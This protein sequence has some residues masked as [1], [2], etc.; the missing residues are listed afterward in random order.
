MGFWFPAF[1]LHYVTFFDSGVLSFCSN[2]DGIKTEVS[3]SYL[4]EVPQLFLAVRA[5]DYCRPLSCCLMKNLYGAS[6]VLRRAW[7]AWA[8]YPCHL[9]L[10]ARI[11]EA[12]NPRITSA[13]P[14]HSINTE[15]LVLCDNISEGITLAELPRGNL[16]IVKQCSSVKGGGDVSAGSN[17]M[18]NSPGLSS[19]AS[20]RSQKTQ[21]CLDRRDYGYSEIMR[22]PTFQRAF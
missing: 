10:L 8:A 9:L 18:L 4:P 1:S 12:P 7:A 16:T 15:H 2:G 21:L 19:N 22:C 6:C 17:G 20:N 3:C 11:A 5:R 13:I 14:A